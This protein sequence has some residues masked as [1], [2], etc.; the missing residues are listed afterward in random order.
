VGMAVAEYQ[1]PLAEREVQVVVAVHVPDAAALSMRVEERVR[2]AEL[3]ELAGD[4]AGEDGAGTVKK[5]LRPFV[6]SHG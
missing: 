1:G 4:A 3:A 5:L 6:A 2:V